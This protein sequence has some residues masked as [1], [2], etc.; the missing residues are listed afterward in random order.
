MWYDKIN[1][2]IKISTRYNGNVEE[3]N[4]LKLKKVRE[5]LLVVLKG[6]E[7]LVERSMCKATKLWVRCWY[8][9][10]TGGTLI[11]SQEKM[12]VER[13]T[14]A[15][16]WNMNFILRAVKSHEGLKKKKKDIHLIKITL[17]SSVENGWEEGW[18]HTWRNNWHS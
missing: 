3:W 10:M 11:E 9:I 15:L 1:F 18:S 2:M 7:G 8:A 12:K 6:E 17:T 5:G 13:K 16:I 14:G 4:L